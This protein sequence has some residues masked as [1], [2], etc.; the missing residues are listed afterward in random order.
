MNLVRRCL[1]HAVMVFVILPCGPCGTSCLWRPPRAPHPLLN[2][3]SSEI[4]RSGR[5]KEKRWKIIVCSTFNMSK[6]S[7]VLKLQVRTL[8]PGKSFFIPE[9]P[10][11]EARLLVLT[12]GRISL[13]EGGICG[14]Q[15]IYDP[16]CLCW[17]VA[18]H[19][20]VSDD[21][22]AGVCGLWL[23]LW[24][25]SNYIISYSSSCIAINPR[26]CFGDIPSWT[27]LAFGSLWE[28]FI[29]GNVWH[30]LVLI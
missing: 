21:V 5:A 25:L 14:W 30:R 12:S 3:D 7:R 13:G 4:P 27:S 18:E 20:A 8:L 11:N 22:F 28:L 10:L 16:L 15:L 29:R 17:S 2:L 26:R 9:T 19:L 23:S 6:T 24:L 1:L